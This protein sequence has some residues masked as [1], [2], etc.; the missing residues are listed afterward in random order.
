MPLT[1]DMAAGLTLKERH[2]AHKAGTCGADCRFC[3]WEFVEYLAHPDH[4]GTF[5]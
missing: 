2:D 5:Y 3:Y 4:G 1:N